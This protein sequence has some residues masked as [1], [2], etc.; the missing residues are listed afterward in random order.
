MD[1][2]P[3][4]QTSEAIRQAESI[5]I[6]TGQHPSVDQTVAVMSLTMILRKF[7]KQANGVISDNLPNAINVLD[8]N[9][10]EKSLGGARDF[11]LK[12]DVTKAEVDKLRYEVIDGKLNVVITPYKGNFAPSDVTF[13]YGDAQATYDLVIVLGVPAR[14]RIDR[15]YEQNTAVLGNVPVINLDFHRSN[16]NYGAVNLIDSNASSLCEIL[17]ALSES[18]Q[19][20]IIDADIATPL[21]MGL[22]ASTDRFTATHTTSKSLTVAAQMMAAGGRQQQVVRALYRD[23]RGGNDSRGSSDNRDRDRDRQ[24]SSKPAVSQSAA[25]QPVRQ[26]TSQQHPSQQRTLQ[27]EP[28]S[29][30]E[31]PIIAPSH[32]EMSK[33]EPERPAPEAVQTPAPAPVQAAASVPRAQV[34]PG[35]LPPEMSPLVDLAAAS[36]EVHPDQADLGMP[37]PSSNRND[38]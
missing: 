7:G 34:A 30:A 8:T 35:Q 18:L 32:I 6:L 23:G 13:G 2:T 31:L 12:L 29:E 17:V 3:K 5:L 24:S 36:A 14:S 38:V 15:L 26:P 16:E 11:V 25:A 9:V 20:G 27:S 22:M 21:L 1:L 4:Q 37:L 33:P 19:S 10:V 28:E